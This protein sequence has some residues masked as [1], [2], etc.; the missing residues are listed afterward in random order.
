MLIIRLKFNGDTTLIFPPFLGLFLR[1]AGVETLRVFLSKDLYKCPVKDRPFEPKSIPYRKK[2][3]LCSTR[4]TALLF[5]EG[6]CHSYYAHEY[7]VSIIPI[8]G[9]AHRRSTPL[10]SRIR[11]QS[12]SERS[13]RG[14][15]KSCWLGKTEE[16]N[17]PMT[18]MQA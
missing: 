4:T 3:R 10:I 9:Y 5:W 11:R 14:D 7:A 6:T 15:E 13:P 1:K 2:K 17:V 16:G 8:I 18:R 12:P